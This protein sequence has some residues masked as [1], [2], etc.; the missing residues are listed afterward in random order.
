MSMVGGGNAVAVGKE[1]GWL[2]DESAM[3]KNTEKIK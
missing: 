1:A 2:Q 3:N